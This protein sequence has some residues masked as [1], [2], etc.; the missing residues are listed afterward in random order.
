MRYVARYGDS[1]KR[2][3]TIRDE[4][5]IRLFELIGE[6]FLQHR[7]TGY[8][9]DQLALTG[10]RLNELTKQ[11]TGKTVTGLIHERIVLEAHRELAFTTKT[12][13]TI[14]ME[15]GYEDPAY[16]CRFFRKMTHES[17][18]GFRGRVFK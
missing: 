7:K 2:K 18:A 8:Y 17:P 5:V 16:F 4:R 9:A 15:L 14:A 12:V 6:H 1:E 13:K 10:K 11:Q 3:A